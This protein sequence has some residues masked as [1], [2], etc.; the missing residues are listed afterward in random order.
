VAVDV[1]C[2]RTIPRPRSEVAAYA[3]DPDNT[4]SWYSNIKAVEWETPRP[5]AV[6]SRVSFIAT[7]LG[8]RLAYTYEIREL[9]SGERLVMSTA[10]GPFPMETTYTWDDAGPGA[11]R[12]TL[13]NRGEPSGF[14]KIAAL[15]MARAMR[16][17]M[18]R[19]LQ[20]LSAVLERR[21]AAS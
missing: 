11:T 2:E 16:R 6:G 10:Q 13:R 21:A 18:T 14:E 1:Q 7:F 20:R 12:M 4:T 8:R 9:V 5:L 15:V 3:A 17:A 19:D